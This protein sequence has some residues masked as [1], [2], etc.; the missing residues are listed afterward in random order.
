MESIHEEGS[1]RSI[2]NGDTMS[3]MVGTVLS[4]FE[5]RANKEKMDNLE[6]TSKIKK[7]NITI[8]DSPM[9]Q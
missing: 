7:I 3:D 2:D 1:M 5:Y 9:K 4:G 6:N 8:L